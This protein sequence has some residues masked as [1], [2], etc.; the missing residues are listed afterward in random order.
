MTLKT[1]AELVAANKYL[2]QMETAI[3]DL[4][5]M[6]TAGNVGTIYADVPPEIQDQILEFAR[7]AGTKVK[8]AEIRNARE[9]LKAAGIEIE[10]VYVERRLTECREIRA[11]SKMSAF[12]RAELRRNSNFSNGANT[13]NSP[14]EI[15]SVIPFNKAH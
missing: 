9:A 4:T 11:S 3:N 7:A 13:V 15:P 2:H 1:P 12:D 10:D 6:E 8:A 5:Y 14:A